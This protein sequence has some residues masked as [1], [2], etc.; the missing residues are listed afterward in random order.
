MISDIIPVFLQFVSFEE[1]IYQ[2]EA[3]GVFNIL[4]PAIL[5]FAIIF[6]ILE[7][8]QTI[9][10]E[11]GINGLIALVLALLIVRVPRVTDFFTVTF[12]GLGI[13]LAVLITV[14]ILAGLFLGNG[15]E[16]WM[17]TLTIGGLIVAAIIVIV[18]LNNFA[19]FGSI[20]WQEN[21]ITM[22]WIVLAFAALMGFINGGKPSKN[23]PVL[24]L[25]GIRNT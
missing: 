14:L 6:A 2:W 12:T 24:P 7:S 21:W 9:S 19:W 10:K 20:W 1:L 18:S 25:A 23:K 22:L 15:M 8:S 13:G 4:L 3:A 5:I 11:R 16:R 17:N